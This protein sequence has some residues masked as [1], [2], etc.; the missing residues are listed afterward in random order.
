METMK[1][2]KVTNTT[3]KPPKLNAQGRDVRPIRDRVGNPVQFVVEGRN[4][5]RKVTIQA[6]RSAIVEDLNEGMLKLFRKG[7]IVVEPIKDISDELKHFTKKVESIPAVSVEDEKEEPPEQTRAK[8]AEAAL[9]KD[10][11]E[12]PKESPFEPKPEEVKKEIDPSVKAKASPMGEQTHDGEKLVNPDGEPNF[13]SRA[14]KSVKRKKSSTW[15]NDK[16]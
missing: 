1:R 7:L 3:Q 10:T 2:Y 11:L 9:K 16:E 15:S 14:N 13:I 6:G 8:V 4:G 5:S 12:A